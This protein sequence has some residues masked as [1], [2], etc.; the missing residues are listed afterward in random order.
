MALLTVDSAHLAAHNLGKHRSLALIYFEKLLLLRS[1]NPSQD[2]AISQ[3]KNDCW[4]HVLYLPVELRPGLAPGHEH[5]EERDQHGQ[6]DAGGVSSADHR[7][8]T[9]HGARSRL[10][11][12]ASAG[13]GVR[14]YREG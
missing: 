8:L 10:Y 5:Q 11:T 1:R 3:I 14:R 12:R 2:H 7:T 9:R 13:A 6:R 4:Y